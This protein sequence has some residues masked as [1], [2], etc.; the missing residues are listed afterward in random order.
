MAAKKGKSKL[1]SGIARWKN[2]FFAASVTLNIA[3]VV[4]FIAMI[5]TNALDLMFMKE[6]LN[7]YCASSNDDKFVDST[8]KVKALRSFTCARGDANDDF[9]NAFSAYLKSKGLE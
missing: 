9:Q 2:F 5:T 1:V 8:A 4:V 6:G 3:F 7:R